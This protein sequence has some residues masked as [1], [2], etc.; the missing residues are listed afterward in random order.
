MV[1][2]TLKEAQSVKRMNP[3]EPL[4]PD[5]VV[6][7][8]NRLDDSVN[9]LNDYL[10]E[11]S[12]NLAPALRSRPWPE[13]THFIEDVS[14]ESCSLAKNIHH[15]HVGVIHAVNVVIGLT[16]ELNL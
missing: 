12:Q 3:E 15:T 10:I 5:N 14:E 7:H 2:K 1:D 9:A 13:N 11:L 6:F 16:R 8:L 4:A